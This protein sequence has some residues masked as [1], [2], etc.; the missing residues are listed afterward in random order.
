MEVYTFKVALDFDK[1]TYRAIEICGNQTLDTF[2]QIIFDAFDRDDEHLYSFY[3][4]RKPI[5]SIRRRYDFSE[6]TNSEAAEEGYSY[7]QIHDAYSATIEQLKINVKDKLYYLF[8]FGDSWW[9]E[10]TLLSITDLNIRDSKLYPKIV[11]KMGK[12]PPQ[13]DFNEDE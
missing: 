6:Y 7:S 3:L 12:S 11:K 10:I 5:R 9:H 13:Y 1:R 2:H 4:T 8:D